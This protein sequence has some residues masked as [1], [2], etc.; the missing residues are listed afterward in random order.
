ME[1]RMRGA[2]QGSKVSLQQEM[3][4]LFLFF[5]LFWLPHVIWSSQARDQI[6][7]T[8]VTYAAAV[9]T[10]K[11][12]NPLHRP[13]IKPVSQHC[14]DTTADPIAPQQEL[15][16]MLSLNVKGDSVSSSE[17]SIPQWLKKI[18]LWDQIAQVWVPPLEH[19]SCDLWACLPWHHHAGE[20]HIHHI[21]QKSASV[22]WG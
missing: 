1:A 22:V 3:P 18:R 10:P 13:W 4:S 11:S 16:E 9:A 19:V 20:H 17:G 8:V 6:G 5:F 12:F 7:A 14:R 2:G 21:R 15:Q